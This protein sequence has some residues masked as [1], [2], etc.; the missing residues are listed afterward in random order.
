MKSNENNIMLAIASV[1]NSFES[2][3][4]FNSCFYS[5]EKNS[6]TFNQNQTHMVPFRQLW[7]FTLFENFI[8]VKCRI[9]SD[10]SLFSFDC[11]DSEAQA[12][13]LYIHI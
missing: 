6:K 3:D 9:H 10:D 1:T 2:S 4:N 13:Y 5:S 7:G 11:H 12:I 8:F